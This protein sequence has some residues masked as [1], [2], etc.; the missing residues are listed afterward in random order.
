MIGGEV[1]HRRFFYPRRGL[2]A[3]HEQGVKFMLILHFDGLYRCIQDLTDGEGGS[4][5]KNGSTVQAGLMCY[6]WLILRGQLVIARGHGGVARCRDATSNVAEYL[7][8][9]EGLQ[10]LEDLGVKDEAVRVCGD[11]KCIIDQMAGRAA[12]NAASIKPLYRRAKKLAECFDQ[13]DWVWMP[14]RD[15][16]QA[17]LLS[18]RAMHQVH[19]D[20]SSYYAALQSLIPQIKSGRPSR[21]FLSLMDLRVYLSTWVI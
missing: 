15:N 21:K 10:A 13:L 6:G 14:R 11:A 8:L 1:S 9:I 17:D 16:K 20:R 2:L 3:V 7:A 4:Q 19:L 5:N 18:R 12:V